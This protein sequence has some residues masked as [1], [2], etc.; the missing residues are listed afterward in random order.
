[1]LLESPSGYGDVV[2]CLLRTARRSNKKNDVADF[3]YDAVSANAM[4]Q[5]ASPPPSHLVALAAIAHYRRFARGHRAGSVLGAFQ[6]SMDS[7]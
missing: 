6:A 5:H 4:L 3:L 1:M 2:A 7:S